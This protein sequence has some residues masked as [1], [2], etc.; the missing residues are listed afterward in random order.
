MKIALSW[1]HHL[2]CLLI[3]VSPLA[4]LDPDLSL[5]QYRMREWGGNAGLPQRTVTDAMLDQDGFLWVATQNGLAR[6]D[7]HEFVNFYQRDGIVRDVFTDGYMVCLFQDREGVI[8][9]GTRSSGLVRYQNGRFQRFDQRHGLPTNF[10]TSLAED[11]RGTLWVGTSGGLVLWRNGKPT[12]GPG[13]FASRP[14]YKLFYDAQN[15]MWIAGQNGLALYDHQ[16][17]VEQVGGGVFQ[18]A[19]VHAVYQTRGGDMWVA[20]VAGGVWVGREET[21]SGAGRVGLA[22]EALPGAPDGLE[23]MTLQED[24]EGNLWLGT[25]TSGLMRYRDGRLTAHRGEKALRN[26]RIHTILEDNEGSLWVGTRNGFFQYYAGRY[27]SIGRAQGLREELIWSVCQAEDGTLW[28]GT[29]GGGLIRW[30]DHVA[31]HYTRLEGMPANEVL[32]V[33]A[34][35][36]GTVWAGTRKGLA[37][38]QDEQ[39]TVFLR[40]DG[41]VGDYI[42]ALQEDREGR[43][44]IGTKSGVSIFQNGGFTDLTE[45][46]GLAFNTVRVFYEDRD[47]AMWIGTDAGLSRYQNGRLQNYTTEQGLISNSVR[48][49]HQD[50]GGSLWVGTYGGLSRFRHGRFDAVTH[51]HGLFQDI[52]FKL[53]EDND[54]N[55][56]MTSHDGFF[57]VPLSEL[58]AIA[59]GSIERLTSH[60]GASARDRDIIECNGGSH[61]SGWRDSTGLLLLPSMSG[62]LILDP[63]YKGTLNWR[64]PTFITEV[65]VDGVRRPVDQPLVQPSEPFRLEVHFTGISYREPKNVRYRVK[66]QGYDAEWEEVGGRR[67]QLYR[68]L[69]PGDYRFRVQAAVEEGLWRES[70]ETYAVTVT[71][72]WFERTGFWV[73]TLLLLGLLAVSGYRYR[74]FS[75]EQQG[76]ELQALVRAR[77]A[78]LEKANH[79][80]KATQDHLVKAAHLAGM[81]EI[82]ADVI[83]NLGNGLNGVNVGGAL[84]KEHCEKLPIT[85]LQR[86][87]ALFEANQE[88]LAVFLQEDPQGRKLIPYLKK[89]VAV[90][91][92]RRDKLEREV[93]DLVDKTRAMNKIIFAQQALTENRDQLEDVGIHEMVEQVLILQEDSL[94]ENHI[95]LVTDFED[96]STV[97]VHKTKFLRALGNLIKNAWE[98]TIMRNA[99]E[100]E[101]RIH[102]FQTDPA[103]V[104]LEIS[105]NGT[106]IPPEDI[107]R[108]F[109]QGYSTKPHGHGF[110]LHYCGNVISEMKG[111]ITVQ[112][113]G[114]GK[115]ATFRVD[116]PVVG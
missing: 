90:L 74:M 116:L 104:R 15:R 30:S 75:L 7:G 68:D 99:A 62:L 47:G 26:L 11:A 28:L 45:K 93:D 1:F 48:A 87:V 108:V 88:Q 66:L 105:D 38:L 112:S 43:I 84:I 77:T 111:R 94:R 54:E 12:P 70:T 39:I 96:R 59:D 103:W 109:H 49:L 86:V 61:P 6:F 98:S 79:E 69:P 3:V 110:S 113:R 71:P 23:V 36:D 91:I 64:P 14:V 57:R 115:G 18:D 67:F 31:R 2:F 95:H 24:R 16:R 32:S 89:S 37:R 52:I 42:R 20:T 76:R 41:L 46:E 82:S 97:R 50:R 81:A 34:A 8:W 102:T 13:A 35:R 17:V 101:V 65:R 53:L 55:L 78:A 22:F 58:H 4:A 107:T 60:I 25:A 72:A 85:K 21:G 63:A 51:H 56:W 19:A 5:D 33:W 10:V 9:I 100:K 40:R 44:W 114:E 92:C 27:F 80:L 106:G 83:H 73:S 29:E